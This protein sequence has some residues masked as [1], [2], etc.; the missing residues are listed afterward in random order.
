MEKLKTLNPKILAIVLIFFV[1]FVLILFLSLFIGPKNKNGGQV[2]LNTPTPAPIQ[3]PEDEL[4]PTPIIQNPVSALTNRLGL[5]SFSVINITLPKK[6]NVYGGSPTPIE[7]STGTNIAQK[8]G[9]TTQGKITSTTNG[10]ALSFQDKGKNLIF[11]LSAGNTQFFNGNATTDKTTGQSLDILSNTAR[12]FMNLF[13]PISDGLVLDNKNIAFMVGGGDVE[14][15]PTFEEATTLDVPFIATIDSY[16]LYSQFG[17][18]AQGHVW[19]DKNGQVLRV[20]LNTKQTLTASKTVEIFT[21]EQAKKQI[22][23]GSGTIVKYGGDEDVNLPTPT[24]TLFTGVNVGYIKDD[25]SKIIYPIFVFE[26]V[27]TTNN[28]TYPIVVYLPAYIGN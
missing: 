4:I 20:T 23:N 1:T 18:N 19:I 25:T 9:I 13:S 7:K 10:D 22:I 14:S 11:Y 24:S 17:S 6:M 3:I 2:T 12:G 28:S 27:A 15:V 21:L 16:P 8:L 5:V 26:G